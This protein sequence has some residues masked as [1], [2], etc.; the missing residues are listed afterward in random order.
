VCG[1]GFVQRAELKGEQTVSSRLRLA[2][3]PT[4]QG[5]ALGQE[6]KKL[7]E[8]VGVDQSVGG[9]VW[10]GRRQEGD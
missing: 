6:L 8:Q 3:D 1:V 2:L 7:V 4:L 5:D 10:G 9:W